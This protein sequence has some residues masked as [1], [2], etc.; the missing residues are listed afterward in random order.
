MRVAFLSG[1]VSRAGGGFFESVR[2]L[3]RALHAQTGVEIAVFG[4]RDEFYSRDLPEWAPVRVEAFPSRGPHSFGR[5]PGL[6]QALAGYSPD[7]VHLHGLWMYSSLVARDFSRRTG[8]PVV[9]SPR[10][11][12]D[13]WALR[14]SRWKKRVARMLFE[15]ANLRDARCIHALSDAECDA[16]RA[17][18][19]RQPVCIVPNGVEIF[20]AVTEPPPW[21]SVVPLG[22]KVLLYLGRL[23]PKKNLL[24]LVRAWSAVQREDA[25][26]TKRWHL[27]IVGWD[28]GGHEQTLREA[29]EQEHLGNI[30]F[31]GPKFGKEKEA[32]FSRAAAFVLPSLS[33]GLPMVVLEA[34][35]YSLPVLM[36][37]ECNLREG[38]DAGAAFRIGPEADSIAGG[39]RSLIRMGES[40]RQAMGRR[41]RELAE[42]QFTWESVGRRM[43]AV[44]RW[45][46]DGGA[47]PACVRASS[48][49]I[50]PLGSGTG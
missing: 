1:S 43:R 47:P 24:N 30:H 11:M 23:H 22:A 50:R 37:E 21:A 34:W 8:R 20:A 5:A 32:A 49:V 4:L 3:A 44:Y 27:V 10:G 12:L 17:F 41:G 28:Q 7:L 6:K 16:V 2:A 35:A 13:P 29:T 42:R 46:L 19:L 15:G 38:F 33:E 36:T 9:V 14:N 25:V 40:E 26:D 48:S 31:L 39:I 45:L 18:G